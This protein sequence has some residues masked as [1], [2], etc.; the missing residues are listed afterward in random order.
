[1]ISSSRIAQLYGYAV[2]LIA[3]VTFLIGVGNLADAAIE[4]ANPLLADGRY[5]RADGSLTSFE[6]YRASAGAMRAVPTRVGP[7]GREIPPDTLTTEQ[8]RARYE[9]LR[10]D[11]LA[12]VSFGTAQRLVKHGLLVAIAIALFLGHRRWLRTREAGDT[13]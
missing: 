4:R 1:M 10:A 11:Q 13:A 5:S 12:R 9:A 6:A 2:C 3:V 7:D 8:L